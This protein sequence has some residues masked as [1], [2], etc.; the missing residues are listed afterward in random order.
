MSK[1]KKNQVP[2]DIAKAIW[3]EYANI[4]LEKFSDQI[5][6]TIEGL[7]ESHPII[8]AQREV[9]KNMK[10]YKFDFNRP[11]KAVKDIKRIS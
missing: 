10:E 5:H 2:V 6:S 3:E 4:I 7:H 8:V 11:K 9:L 1:K